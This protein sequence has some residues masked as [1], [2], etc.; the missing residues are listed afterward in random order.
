MGRR[1][2]GMGYSSIDEISYAT[3]IVSLCKHNCFFVVEC[4]YNLE[5]SDKNNYYQYVNNMVL[6]QL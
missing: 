5:S 4:M 2:P 3:F 6:G 1:T